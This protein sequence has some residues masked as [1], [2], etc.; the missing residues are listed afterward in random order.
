MFASSRGSVET[1]LMQRLILDLAAHM[2]DNNLNL[3]CWL[4]YCCGYSKEPFK[5][6]VVEFIS[7]DKYVFGTQKNN[8]SETVLLI[9]LTHILV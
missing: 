8:L 5:T 7:P 9:T 6:C 1:A 3:M 2:C 4:I